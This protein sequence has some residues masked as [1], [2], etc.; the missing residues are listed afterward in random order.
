MG[1][2]MSADTDKNNNNKIYGDSDISPL[3]LIYFQKWDHVTNKSN[4]ECFEIQS[5]LPIHCA[6]QK[7]LPYRSLKHFTKHI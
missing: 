7:V 4:N 2:T 3:A 5:M 6:F 1:T